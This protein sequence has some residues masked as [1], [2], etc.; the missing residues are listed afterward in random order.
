MAGDGE[1]LKLVFCA[2]E[3]VP[4]VKTGGLA[5]VCGSLSKA[6]AKSKIDVA[7]FLPKYSCIDEKKFNLKKINPVLW[8]TKV[9]KHFDV[10]FI[11]NDSYFKRDR[12][13]GDEHG[14]FSDNLERF[15]FFNQEILRQL[16]LLGFK[17][18][19]IHCH[20]WQTALIPVYLKNGW[21]T[22]GFFAQTKTLLSVHN[23]AFQGVFNE[24]QFH[25][26]GLPHSSF[27]SF[28]HYEKINFLKAGMIH[29]DRVATVSPQYSKEIESKEFGCGLEG[30]VRS[31]NNKVIG[32]LNGVNTEYWNPESD[33]LLKKRYSL[34]SARDGKAANKKEL[35]KKV[36]FDSNAAPI[37]GMVTRLTHQKGV[38]L[39]IESLRNILSLGARVVVV[40]VGD[41][42]YEQQLR[43]LLEEN[44]A[45][46]S[47][48]F[49]FNEELAHLI[50]AG[51]DFFLM[52]SRFEP[53]GLTQMIAMRYGAVPVAHKT[54][55]LAD[56]I[57]DVVQD[58]KNAT[59]I[60][61]LDFSISGFLT[62]LRDAV[63]IYQDSNMHQKIIKNAMQRD[64]SL[65]HS[66]SEYKKIYSCLL[67]A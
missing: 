24:P 5:D 39:L 31:L 21:D 46:L 56:T 4:F 25:L 63:K 51:S 37:F 15:S 36:G 6:L 55:G 28:M 7:L 3:A 59:G 43:E 35:Q 8:H 62:A 11:A 29:A 20:D 44:K 45:N 27:E 10:Y 66:A 12:I 49:E 54:G 18:D 23:M 9:S 32:V 16:E 58:E 34:N 57:S 61:F 14:D 48:A 30:V 60:L 64:F 22:A 41:K 42:I 17:P 38:D 67:S 13:Y 53:C 19:V 33:Q 2:S 1:G 40:G 50:Y 26:L 52:P 65:E 47:V